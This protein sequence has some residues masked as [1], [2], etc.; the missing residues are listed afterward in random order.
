ML[1]TQN[2]NAKGQG[3][4]GGHKPGMRHQAIFSLDYETWQDLVKVLDI[5]K[6]L[7]PD[8]SQDENTTQIG[9]RGWYG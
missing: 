3:K 4:A 6:P 1:S 7:I 2:G 5:K 8:R 9:A